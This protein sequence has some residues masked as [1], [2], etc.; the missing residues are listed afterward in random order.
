M[1]IAA[2]LA[3]ALC[4]ACCLGRGHNPLERLT[5]AQPTVCS[6]Y[7]QLSWSMVLQKI[8]EL[9]L[10][11]QQRVLLLWLFV[12][13]LHLPTAMRSDS[14]ASLLDAV[15]IK[16]AAQSYM[17]A[18]MTQPK[19]C[20]PPA[21]S[22]SSKATLSHAGSAASLVL[23][24]Q[25]QHAAGCSSNH[26]SGCDTDANSSLNGS[27]CSSSALKYSKD[28][29]CCGVGSPCG[30]AGAASIAVTAMAGAAVDTCGIMPSGGERLYDRTMGPFA[31]PAAAAAAAAAVPGGVAS[32]VAPQMYCPMQQ[33]WA[34]GGCAGLHSGT[35]SPV[36]PCALFPGVCE[37]VCDR[38]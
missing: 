4:C 34:A 12:M 10:C 11:H 37:G 3:T 26:T 33:P 35:T 25:A 22:P 15:N 20:S 6:P 1:L 24:Q 30:G 19:Q 5:T 17:K 8:S 18:R 31:G 27:S 13:Q 36:G 9:R 14:A 32:A 28:Q 2:H 29:L 23:K 21:T 38:M 7:M 16:A